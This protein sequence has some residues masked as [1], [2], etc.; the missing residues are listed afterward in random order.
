MGNGSLSHLLLFAGMLLGVA[1]IPFGLP[2]TVVIL[3]CVLFYGIATDFAAGVGIVFL[4]VLGI[5]TIISETADNWL[6]A[7]GA[8]RFGASSGSMWLSFF[9]GLGG[10]VLLGGPLVFFAGPF[11]PV[12]GGFAG[13]FMAVFFHEYYRQRDARQALRAGWGTFVGRM[14]GMVL[15]LVIALAM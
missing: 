3:A 12:I 11:G 2:G 7:L 15:K 13:A 6:T 4:V 5:L 9:G 14:A 8:R 1:I 10:A